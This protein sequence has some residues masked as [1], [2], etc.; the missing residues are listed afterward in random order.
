[1][2]YQ[3]RHSVINVTAKSNEILDKEMKRKDETDSYC[4]DSSDPSQDFFNDK[5]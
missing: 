3:Y 5:R 4:S 2:G 1:M